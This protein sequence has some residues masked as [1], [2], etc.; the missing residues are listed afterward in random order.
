MKTQGGAGIHP[1]QYH[2]KPGIVR[3]ASSHGK[4][5]NL[6][7]VTV[8]Q[9]KFSLKGM[10]PPL[11]ASEPE[12]ES[13]V[14][15]LLVF[16]PSVQVCIPVRHGI[17][18]R[19]LAGDGLGCTFCVVL[20]QFTLGP[21]PTRMPQE[22]PEQPPAFKGPCDP[23][24]PKEPPHGSPPSQA[25]CPAMPGQPPFHPDNQA[26]VRPQPTLRPTVNK[27]FRGSTAKVAPHFSRH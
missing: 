24:A 13:V 21:H 27:A 7:E 22:H 26:T 15:F 6:P 2:P 12:I 3:N 25:N 20:L 1:G 8:V 17:Q 5:V 10:R 4:A 18:Q 23:A 16:P 14:A 11:N 19:M 9:A